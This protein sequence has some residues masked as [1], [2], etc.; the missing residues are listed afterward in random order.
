ME[1]YYPNRHKE[2]VV[3]PIWTKS[4]EDG[5]ESSGVAGLT[6]RKET[7]ERVSVGF[8]AVL[9]QSYPSIVKGGIRSETSSDLVR[10]FLTEIRCVPVRFNFFHTIGDIFDPK[11]GRMDRALLGHSAPTLPEVSG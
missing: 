1:Q 11:R 2:R 10:L 7:V 5:R 8:S 4:V 3:G 9:M 6:R